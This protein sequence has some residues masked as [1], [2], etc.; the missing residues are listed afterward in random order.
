MSIAVS[1]IAD[2]FFNHYINT[3]AY[4]VFKIYSAVT[5]SANNINSQSFRW[6]AVKTLFN[7]F[8]FYF[9]NKCWIIAF[10][11]YIHMSAIGQALKCI[12]INNAWIIS[13]GDHI[14][15]VVFV[16]CHRTIFKVRNYVIACLGVNSVC[17]SSKAVR[18]TEINLV[19]IVQKNFDIQIF[20]LFITIICI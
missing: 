8:V 7:N 5:C 14:N 9:D 16:Q 19:F 3:A 20:R 4:A 18:K 11:N 2:C 17:R 13:I 12:V 15:P 6:F 10:R 1:I